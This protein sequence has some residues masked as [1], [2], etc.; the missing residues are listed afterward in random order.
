M[1]TA[2]PTSASTTSS[3]TAVASRA[4]SVA[5][6]SRS[7]AFR[8]ETARAA[9][10]QMRAPTPEVLADDL[11]VAL[12]L[13]NIL[14]DLREDADNGRVYLPAEDLRRFGL[15]P[16]AT[17]APVWQARARAAGGARRFEA[18][19]AQEWF[20]RGL[21]LAPCWTGAVPRA[22]CAMA[23]IYRRLLDRI[24]AH[25]ERRCAS[26]CRCPRARRRGVAA[27][28]MLGGDT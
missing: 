24:E 21:Q 26:E 6:A 5:R 14:R 19:R 9:G 11:G 7:S 15:P 12:Q 17:T 1:S 28:S 27:R 10:A 25:P 2:S 8:G 22:C 18:E 20:E 16:G 3:F 4:R 13:T 23:G